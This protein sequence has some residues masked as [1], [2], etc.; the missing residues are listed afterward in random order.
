MSHSKLT[1]HIPNFLTFINISLGLGAIILLIRSNHPYKT[2]AASI[3]VVLG[4]FCDL[5]DGFLAR[6]FNVVT[7]MGKQLDSFADIVTFGIAPILLINYT[8]QC[9]PPTFIVS[10]SLIFVM[11]GTYRLA[12][13][14]Q[15]DFNE[16]FVGLPI[17]IAGIGLTFYC[18]VY[19]KWSIYVHDVIC[20]AITILV[21]IL[22][23]FMMISKVKIRR[24]IT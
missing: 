3:L 19:P 14:N 18:I 8:S 24:I 21:I 7:S 22:L 9:K 4:S 1:R 13:Y 2:L 5:F 10:A 6:R 15:H 20:T 23:S 16:N 11:A 12:R 17:T